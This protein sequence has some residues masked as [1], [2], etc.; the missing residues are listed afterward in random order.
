MSVMYAA[1]TMVSMMMLLNAIVNVAVEKLHVHL[2]I[3]K[4]R[5]VELNIERE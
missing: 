4:M 3:Q 5:I 2:D 1:V